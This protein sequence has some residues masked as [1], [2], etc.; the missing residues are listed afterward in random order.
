M[1]R[2]PHVG[3][4]LAALMDFT[5]RA[6]QVPFGDCC[7]VSHY[8]ARL[9]REAAARELEDGRSVV[10]RIFDWWESRR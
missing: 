4:A 7:E 9:E 1:N 8:V 6:G 10:G 3:R 2:P 5:A